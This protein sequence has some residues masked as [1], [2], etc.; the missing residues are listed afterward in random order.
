[1]HGWISVDTS[2]NRIY[3][4]KDNNGNIRYVY[5]FDHVGE[6]FTP[7]YVPDE[8]IVTPSPTPVPSYSVI[9]TSEPEGSSRVYW[10]N[11]DSP[12]YIVAIYDDINIDAEY[13]G[14]YYGEWVLL[15]FAYWGFDD[16]HNAYSTYYL[17]D[18]DY[19][20]DLDHRI[21]YYAYR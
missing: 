7:V 16:T 11:E 13:Y 1:M 14:Y 5:Y 8:L 2:G 19:D 15:D 9:P 20:A 6:D 4:Y 17:Y 12:Y 3:G 21:I 10:G 18:Y